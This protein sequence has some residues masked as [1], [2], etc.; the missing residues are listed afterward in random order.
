MNADIALYFGYT[1]E[2]PESSAG[3]SAYVSSRQELLPEGGVNIYRQQYRIELDN[4]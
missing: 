4:E 1:G 3:L 2:V